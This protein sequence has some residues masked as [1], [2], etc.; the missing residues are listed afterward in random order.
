MSL[1]E[2]LRV[3]TLLDTYGKLLTSKQLEILSSYY[4]DNLTLSEIADIN[5]ISRQAVNDCITKTIKILSTYEE[6]L[7]L[8][9]KNNIVINKLNEIAN[10]SNSV[11]LS[12]KVAEI[13]EDIRG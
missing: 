9:E 3:I 8:I 1:E 10:E 7:N 11:E 5:N 12:T 13:I 2:N 6:K 4:Y